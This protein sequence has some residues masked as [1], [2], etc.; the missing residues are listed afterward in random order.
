MIS[1]MGQGL[2]SVYWRRGK[3]S[4]L[5]NGMYYRMLLDERIADAHY[6]WEYYE[7]KARE[8]EAAYN[9]VMRE[10]KAYEEAM[11]VM[12]GAV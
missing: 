8:A 1:F 9:A 7:K 6:N 3:R 10:K 12:E 5:V 4:V 11:K 2:I